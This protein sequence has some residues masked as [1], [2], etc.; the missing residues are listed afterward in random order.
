MYNIYALKIQ[1]N[2]RLRGALGMAAILL[3]GLPFLAAEPAVPLPSRERFHLYLLIGQSNMAGRG[4]V[5]AEDKIPHPR[6]LMFT[7][8][9]EW[10]PAVDPLHFD[11]R[12]AAVGLGSTF[13]RVIADANPDVTIGL[14]PAAVSGT[15]LERWRK[16]GD[17]YA[18][19]VVR[20]QAAMKD[21][22][23]KGI[24][25]HQGE[26]DTGDRTLAL[27][28]GSRLGGMVG[29]LRAELGAGDVPFLAGLLGDFVGETASMD[30]ESRAWPEK[31][32]Y[33]SVVNDQIAG[34]PA[35]LPHSAVVSANGL[36]A[37]D[38][39]HFD[40]PSLREFGRRYAKALADLNR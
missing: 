33:W 30:G 19:A 8:A 32:I 37:F 16:G 3:F 11:K 25:W 15:P 39:V 35:H 12:S 40:A 9:Q 2:T 1:Y 18:Q 14:I 36:T 7:K 29:D 17:L 5:E 21:G 28:Y 20:A 13:A 34:L 10:A 23:L 6:V 31:P 26:S 38:G 27:T 24:L 4:R 22:T